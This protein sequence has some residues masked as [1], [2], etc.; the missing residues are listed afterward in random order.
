MISNLFSQIDVGIT[1][2]AD[3]QATIS[4]TASGAQAYDAPFNNWN[5]RT[6][7]I[8]WVTGD[9]DGITGITNVTGNNF[10]QVGMALEDGIYSYAIFND[11]GPSTFAISSGATEP[12]LTIDFSNGGNGGTAVELINDAFTMTNCGTASINHQCLA[13]QCNACGPNSAEVL[14]IEL[15]TFTAVKRGES[16]QLDWTTASEVNASHFD[17][18]RSVNGSEWTVIGQVKA[19]GESTELVDYDLIDN[20]VPVFV[21]TQ[22]LAYYRLNMIDNDGSAA[23]S[24]VRTV[25]FEGRKEVIS[26]HPNPTANYINVTSEFEVSNV[27]ILD[28]NGK[29]ILNQKYQNGIIDISDLKNGMYKVIVSTEAGDHVKSVIKID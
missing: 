22:T 10:S 2:D 9:G 21:N 29:L 7:T 20:N 6:F 1:S 19:R 27:R 5:S 14:P 12:V 4:L 26:I 23:Y 17:V 3:N 16:A 15:K 11:Q 24:D 28:I 18:E 8:R 13:E 25:S